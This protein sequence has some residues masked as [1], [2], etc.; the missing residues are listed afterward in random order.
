M[1]NSTLVSISQTDTCFGVGC[2]SWATQNSET[3]AQICKVVLNRSLGE[4]QFIPIHPCCSHWREKKLSGVQMQILQVTNS[5]TQHYL[6]IPTAPGTEHTPKHLTLSRW[7]K[8][9]VHP[10]VTEGE[11]QPRDTSWLSQ[12]TQQQV[13]GLG[14]SG[15]H[16]QHRSKENSPP[17]EAQGGTTLKESPG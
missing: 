12:G 4:R 8:K 13:R 10:Y 16:L 14:V 2:A 3:A 9:W 17:S 5:T 11:V 6:H 7:A 1:E 15:T